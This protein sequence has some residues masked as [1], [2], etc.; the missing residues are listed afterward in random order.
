MKI[1]SIVNQKGGV[2][3]T[4]TTLSLG[5]AL[6]EQGQRVLIVDLDPQRNATTSLFGGE[7]KGLSVNDLIYFAVRQLPLQFED[8]IRYNDKENLDYIPSVPDLASAPSILAGCRD[9]N[10]VL[11]SIL[12]NS[13]FENRYDYILIDDKPSLDL[14]VVN[15]LV[16]SHELI[17]PV[18]PE[19]YA[20]DGLSDL[21][22]TVKRIQESFNYELEINGILISR[23]NMQRSKT[24]DADRVLREVFGEL[25]YDTVIPN[26]AAIGHAAARGVTV[27]QVKGSNMGALYRQLAKE[28]T[29]R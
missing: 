14:L 17:I 18:E 5:A 11:A 12:R 21:M 28:V 6:A 4:T 23:A 20:I 3:K 7:Y 8:Y 22:D 27:V 16:A 15:S 2:G 19:D 13:Y 1:I 9:S 10:T 24:R 25:V 26:W 29:N